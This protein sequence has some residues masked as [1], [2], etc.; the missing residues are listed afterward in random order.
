M[1]G[2]M[3]WPMYSSVDSQGRVAGLQLIREEKILISMLL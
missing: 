1:M 2:D 3:E